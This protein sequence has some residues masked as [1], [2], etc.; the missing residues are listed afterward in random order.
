V[1]AAVTD[2]PATPLR[3]RKKLNSM[4]GWKIYICRRIMS[5]NPY[6][7][8][9]DEEADEVGCNESGARRRD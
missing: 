4:R 1:K 2:V 8:N 3:I 6:S 7:D 9:T 5:I